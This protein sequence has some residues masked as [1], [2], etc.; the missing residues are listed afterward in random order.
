MEQI[1][2]NI[3]DNAIR[4]TDKK[5]SIS[6]NLLKHPYGCKIEI[7]DTGFG[8]PENDIEKITSRFYRVNKA[9]SR[10]NGGT[11]LGLA[12]TDKLVKLHNGKMEITSKLGE[13]TKVAVYFPA[14]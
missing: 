4:Y 9:R 13:G 5:G 2:Q 14:V 12:I 7:A 8:I 11:G 1:L 10:E 6:I 3:M